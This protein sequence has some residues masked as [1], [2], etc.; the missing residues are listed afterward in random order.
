MTEGWDYWMAS[1]TRQTRVWA[2]SSS[3]VIVSEAW[4]AVVHGVAE[5][6]I[7]EQLNWT[8]LSVL[9]IISVQFSRS[10][11]SD[12][13]TPWSAA[14]QVSLTF[15]NSRSLLKL[16]YICTLISVKFSSVTQLC[17]THMF[18]NNLCNIF[19]HIDE[20]SVEVQQVWTGNHQAYCKCLSFFFLT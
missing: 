19:N 8:E 20:I 10:I 16:M 9:R 6:D 2:S 12:S 11:M 15:S 18:T 13:V 3:L 1:P 4:C 5:L 17:P 7:T 14:R